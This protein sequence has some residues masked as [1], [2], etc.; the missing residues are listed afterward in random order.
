MTNYFVATDIFEWRTRGAYV[1]VA[2]PF[3]QDSAIQRRKNNNATWAI[4]R[5]EK[6][7]SGGLQVAYAVLTGLH[8]VAGIGPEC[9]ATI[10]HSGD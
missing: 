9:M 1:A 8:A 6:I 4:R 10:T 3:A 5:I 7:T 2:C